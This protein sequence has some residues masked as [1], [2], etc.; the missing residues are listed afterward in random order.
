MTVLQYL[1]TQHRG[2]GSV[3]LDEQLA[4]WRARYPRGP[5]DVL[6]E[7]DAAGDFRYRPILAGADLLSP[8]VLVEVLGQERRIEVIRPRCDPAS[9]DD[10]RCMDRDRRRASFR[11]NCCPVLYRIGRN[12]G[13]FARER[14]RYR[15]P[16][17]LNRYS[18]AVDCQVTAVIF[19]LYRKSHARTNHPAVPGK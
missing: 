16:V 10:P 13:V 15:S 18:P 1:G 3:L 17:H 11:G 7:I 12:K 2:T 14:I 6:A 8:A 5:P 19:Q 9:A 4:D